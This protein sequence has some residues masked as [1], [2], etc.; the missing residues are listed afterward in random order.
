M[1]IIYKHSSES[2]LDYLISEVEALKSEKSSEKDN[3]SHLLDDNIFRY[4][5][6]N[7]KIK[8]EC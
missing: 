8:I 3:N 6:E 5:D 1:L 7:T 2:A 4:K